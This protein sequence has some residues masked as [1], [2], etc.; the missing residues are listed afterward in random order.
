[1]SSKL[2]FSRNITIR[3]E[4]FVFVLEDSYYEIQIISVIKLTYEGPLNLPGYQEWAL[5]LFMQ[6]LR[7]RAF[8][9]KRQKTRLHQC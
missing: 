9:F 6:N 1:M 5:S 4:D 7:I 3:A 2:L 8:H